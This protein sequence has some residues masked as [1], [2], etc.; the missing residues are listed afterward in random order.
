[1][2]ELKRQYETIKASDSLKERIENTMKQERMRKGKIIKSCAGAVA[3][4][5][6][7]SVVGVNVMPGFADALAAVPGLDQVVRVITFGRYQSSEGGY[8]A[9]ITTPQIEGLLDKE[10]EDKLNKEFK[11]NANAIIAAYEQ[12]VKE[13]KAEFGDETVHMGIDSDYIVKTD[14]DKHLALDVYILYTAGSSSTKHAF[15]TI[16]K[17]SGALLTLPGLFKEGADY[18]T[19]ISA[20]IKGEMERRN[21]EEEGLFWLEGDEDAFEGFNQIKPEQN[22]YINNDGN[23]VIA[24]DKYEVAAGAQGSPEFVIPNTVIADLLK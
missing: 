17:Q 20:Y 4:L 9:D 23:L 3:C 1:M 8:E 19:P 10:L 2:N 5:M 16:D 22:F 18:V 14:N 7:L 21:R 15:Y 12:D 6:V 13:L 11:E 24:F